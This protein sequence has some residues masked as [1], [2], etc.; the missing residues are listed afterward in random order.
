MILHACTPDRARHWLCSADA[1]SREA[2][3][4]LRPR[5]SIEQAGTSASA[6]GR[7]PSGNFARP[8]AGGGGRGQGGAAAGTGDPCKAPAAASAREPAAAAAGGGN[9][10]GVGASSA[11]NPYQLFAAAPAPALNP[12]PA[13]TAAPLATSQLSVKAASSLKPY[14]LFPQ[15]PP[16]AAPP[17]PAAPTAGRESA[18][19]KAESSPNLYAAFSQPAAAGGAA[20]AS[21]RNASASNPYEVFMQPAD[22]SAAGGASSGAAAPPASASTTSGAGIYDMFRGAEAAA[23]HTAPAGV[24]GAVEVEDFGDNPYASFSA[25]PTTARRSLEMPLGDERRKQLPVP[26]G[27]FALP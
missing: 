15:P 12:E 16:A 7:L 25:V 20:A 4:E 9:S 17:S 5:I 19:T 1:E 26:Q 21:T 23:A 22:G 10:A 6:P 18:S 2:G 8:E 14:E 11:G 13:G 27:G 3:F 24:P